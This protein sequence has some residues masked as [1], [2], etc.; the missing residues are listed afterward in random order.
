MKKQPNLE[1]KLV[2]ENEYRRENQGA[3]VAPIYQN[4]LFTFENWD[5]IDSAFSDRN[6]S[7]IYTRQRNPSVAQVEEKLAMLAGA[8]RAKLFGSGIGAIT[9]AVVHFLKPGDHIIA[10]KNCY[11]PTNNLLNTFLREKMD[12]ETIFVSGEKI[13]DFEEAIT[14]RTRL[15]YLESPSSAIFTLQDIESV[16]KLAKSKNIKT[17]IDNSWATPIFQQPLKLG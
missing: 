10:V 16:C 3:V 9:A 6:N 5:A 14:K 17:V 7:N 11:G 8:E 13:I 4:S 12:I 15:I 1:T 2:H